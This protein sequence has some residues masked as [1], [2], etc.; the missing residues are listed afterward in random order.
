[1]SKQKGKKK[2]DQ[3]VM[4]P[5]EEVGTSEILSGIGG[6][7]AEQL[8]SP[9]G[10]LQFHALIPDAVASSSQQTAATSPHADQAPSAALPAW[11]SS[12]ATN[13][14]HTI[15]R[16]P[17]PVAPARPYWP[18]EH[19]QDD[20]ADNWTTVRGGHQRQQAVAPADSGLA[21]IPHEQP[22]EDAEQEEEDDEKIGL[23]ALEGYYPLRRRG[24]RAGKRHKKRYGQ[25]AHAAYDPQ[26]DDSDH[27][28]VGVPI[29]GQQ[30][31]SPLGRQPDSSELPSG[32]GLA[33]RGIAAV[34]QDRHAAAEFARLDAARRHVSAAQLLQQAEAM[35]AHDSAADNWPALP[36][37]MPSTSS[38]GTLRLD[39]VHLFHAI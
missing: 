19:G 25:N 11:L 36:G 4:T 7:A 16:Q 20:S 6:S 13:G 26:D 30:A 33:T 39:C 24:V 28:V 29:T 15:Q 14:R 31:L 8:F 35:G 21:S 10:Q 12:A 38:S 23:A 17:S 18:P 9:T 1:M 5:P 32:S 22:A 2:K 27:S 37:A 34:R 3:Q